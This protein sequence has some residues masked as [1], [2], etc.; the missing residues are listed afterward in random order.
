MNQESNGQG[1][2]EDLNSFV[3]RASRVSRLAELR[4]LLDEVVRS[5][6]FDYFALVHHVDLNALPGGAVSLMTYPTSWQDTLLERRY[7]I[8]DPVL[9]ACEKTALGFR[10]SQ[11]SS[12]IELNP[13]HRMIFELAKSE[14]L[15]DGFT[16]PVHVPGDFSGSCSFGVRVGQDL[17]QRSFPA[18]QYL[19]CFAFEAARRI[20]RTNSPRATAEEPAHLTERQHD[21]L[22]LAARG[23]SERET[24]LLLDV[25]PDTVHKHLE[26]ARRRYGA[27]SKSQ[28][29][30]RALYNSQL[31]FSDIMREPKI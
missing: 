7:Y 28:L 1:A 24:A 27:S 5:L 13:R 29:I 26:E 20:V 25:K 2:F 10:W 21:C 9:T 4:A 22:V 11:V 15:G 3:R 19:G 17:P 8:E 31:S 12:L 14:G 23:L 6:G 18:A 16:V 30:V